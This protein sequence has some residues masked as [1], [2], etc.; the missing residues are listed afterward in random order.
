M[1]IRKHDDYDQ[2]INQVI[3]PVFF[4]LSKRLKKCKK[5]NKI[6]EAPRGYLMV[7]HH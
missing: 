3:N 5:K 4:S 1:I 7:D 6:E 2:S